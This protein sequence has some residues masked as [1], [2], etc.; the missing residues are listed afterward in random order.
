MHQGILSWSTCRWRECRSACWRI[1][2]FSSCL[3]LS[4]T[5]APA[6]PSFGLVSLRSPTRSAPVHSHPRRCNCRPSSWA[7][8]EVGCTHREAVDTGKR[9]MVLSCLQTD[10]PFLLTKSEEGTSLENTKGRAKG[11]NWA[12]AFSFCIFMSARH[13]AVRERAGLSMEKAHL[14]QAL[15]SGWE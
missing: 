3:S 12:A 15:P 7:E 6:A 13:S 11:W 2:G 10:T 9:R 1:S 5:P 8:A 14:A 4:R